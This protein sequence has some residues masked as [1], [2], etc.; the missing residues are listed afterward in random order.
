M[1]IEKEF[2]LK[3]WRLSALDAIEHFDAVL[4][5]R[6]LRDLKKSLYGSEEER[7]ENSAAKRDID[8]LKRNL[9][10]TAFPE[11]PLA[12]AQKILSAEI[13]GFLR[14]DISLDERLSTRNISTIYGDRAIEQQSLRQA[15]LSNQEKIGE[16]VIGEW[17]KLFDK[18]YDPLTRNNNSIIDFL[19]REPRTASLSEVERNLLRAVLISYENWLAIGRM[20]IYDVAFLYRKD[21]KEYPVGTKID[22]SRMSRSQLNDMGNG[23]QRPTV[24]G[25]QQI[26]QSSL[27]QALSKYENLGNQLITEERIRVKSQS[28]PV[29]PSLLH[30]IK[31]YRDELGVGHHDSVQRGQFLFR[32]ENGRRLS[33]QERERVGLI[34]KSV[35]ENF[36]LSIDTER[37]EI[38]FPA[39][40]GVTVGGR[41][42]PPAIPAN[43][44]IAKGP[45]FF[46]VAMESRRAEKVFAPAHN[47]NENGGP[48][49]I[50]TQSVSG[51]LHIGR[52]TDFTHLQPAAPVSAAP[53]VP[54]PARNDSGRVSFSAGHV[55]PAEKEA[56]ENKT[57]AAK[58]EAQGTQG[59]APRPV[60]QPAPRVNPFR[61]NPVSL[62]KKK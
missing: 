33:A 45:E 57:V 49:H 2:G 60:S 21:G 24:L 41:K 1:E 30:W 48:A 40:Q 50:A 54:A 47:P 61:I 59:Q 27:L 38:I 52:G 42:E 18:N 35:E 23:I 26:I 11:L 4:A 36:P 16:V 44:R 7:L 46:N 22:Y 37:Q 43:A 13:L 9:R 8:E 39:F 5:H 25:A 34:L 56:A 12:E 58:T 32:S 29:R 10:F 31:Y 19:T 3:E 51:G 55:F 28:E 20:N 53:G 15:I 14:S 17:L 62:G 6:L